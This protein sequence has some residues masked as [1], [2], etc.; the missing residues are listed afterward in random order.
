MDLFFDK[1]I[2]NIDKF[3]NECDNIMHLVIEFKNNDL[4]NKYYKLFDND[5]VRVLVMQDSFSDR[6][7]VEVFGYGTSKYDAIKSSSNVFKL[8]KYA[9]SSSLK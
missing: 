6:K 8:R 3:I 9:I 7:W 2:K 1:E 5:K 4:V